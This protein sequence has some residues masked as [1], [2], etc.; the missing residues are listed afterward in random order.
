MAEKTTTRLQRLLRDPK[1]LQMPGGFS[2]IAAKMCEVAGYESFFLAG[3]QTGA[4]V[5]GVPDVGILDRGDMTLAAQRCA[6]GC[7]IPV[8]VDSDTGYGNSINVYHAVQGY[9]RAG[10]AG[11]HL[12]D[13]DFPKRSGTA[14]GRRCIS[15]EEAA[16]KYKAAM[17]AKQDLDPDFVICARCDLI[18]AENGSFEEAVERCIYYVEEA[19]VDLIWLNNIQTAEECRI[20]AER[21]PGPVIPHFAGPPPAPSMQDLEDW[22]VAA[23]IYPGMTTGIGLQATWEYINDFKERS[24]AASRDARQHFTGKWGSVR[25]DTFATPGKD[26]VDAIERDYLLA[27]QQRDYETTFGHY[28]MDGRP[29]KEQSGA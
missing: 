15:K 10:A 16:L 11:L 28:G 13:Q 17:A 4:F 26:L 21:I 6:G 27:D 3:S 8:F 20:A 7:N 18:G 9:I 14:G 19:G 2:P 1:V 12:E 24:D 23:I 25:F 22:G 29:T 5:Y